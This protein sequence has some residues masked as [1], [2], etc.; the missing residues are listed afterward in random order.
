[1]T[2]RSTSL[3]MLSP[4]A[5]LGISQ[6]RPPEACGS[7]ASAT[8]RA[9]SQPGSLRS[10][11]STIAVSSAWLLPTVTRCSCLWHQADAPGDDLVDHALRQPV[12]DQVP[13][14]VRRDLVAD[15]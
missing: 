12:R 6:L 3:I 5:T 15:F 10:A 13:H 1:M 8:T 11:S 4:S 7:G 2:A 9:V 14:R